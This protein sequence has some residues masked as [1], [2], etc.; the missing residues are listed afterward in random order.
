[1]KIKCKTMPFTQHLALNNHSINM[2]CHYFLILTTTKIICKGS[3][4]LSNLPKDT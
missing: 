3:E 4:R 2:C 1:M